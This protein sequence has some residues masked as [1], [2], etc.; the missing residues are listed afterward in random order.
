MERY[1]CRLKVTTKLIE[2]VLGIKGKIIG[3]EYDPVSMNMVFHVL[4]DK[5]HF[6]KVEEGSFAPNGV[7]EVKVDENKIIESTLIVENK[8]FKHI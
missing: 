4:G 8:R 3:C 6:P 2:H 5:E 7:M 1:G